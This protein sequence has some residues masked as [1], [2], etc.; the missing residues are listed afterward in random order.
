MSLL[1]SE[2][3]I[4][5]DRFSAKSSH[6]Y[7]APLILLYLTTCT[8]P[9]VWRRDTNPT[10]SSSQRQQAS[11][12]CSARVFGAIASDRGPLQSSM[13]SAG[14]Q[15]SLGSLWL[16]TP[17]KA[18]LHALWLPLIF[19]G[20]NFRDCWIDHKNNEYYA[21]INVM[22]NYP[23]PGHHRGQGGDLTN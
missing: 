20:G 12:L 16:A 13:P 17:T 6:S 3:W 7:I 15:C 9:W 5:F 4:G 23:P 1:P 18:P 2:P 19:T 21:P 8:S 14:R 10:F 22:P 11:R